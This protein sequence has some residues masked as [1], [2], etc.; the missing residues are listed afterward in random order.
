[1]APELLKISLSEG[2]TCVCSSLTCTPCLPVKSCVRLVDQVLIW[3][4]PY[5][6]STSSRYSQSTPDP[7]NYCNSSYGGQNCPCT[8]V[9]IHI[10]CRHTVRICTILTISGSPTAGIIQTGGEGQ[11]AI[12]TALTKGCIVFS[13]DLSA[14]S[15]TRS[16]TPA[17][18]QTVDW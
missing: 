18:R 15:S 16:P 12:I 2:N 4:C 3:V 5:S 7:H 11:G 10:Y 8:Y 13:S 14:S 1:M 9:C 6:F 17:R